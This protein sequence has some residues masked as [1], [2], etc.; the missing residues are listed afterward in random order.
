MQKTRYEGWW[1]AYLAVQRL[2]LDN[3]SPD[4]EYKRWVDRLRVGQE[5]VQHGRG[6]CSDT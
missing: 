6:Y 1:M 5:T 4:T 3:T 2:A